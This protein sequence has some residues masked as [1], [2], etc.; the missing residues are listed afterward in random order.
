MWSRPKNTP[1][2]LV[3][4]L[5]NVPAATVSTDTV[6]LHPLTAGIKIVMRKSPA[7]LVLLIAEAVMSNQR[8][9][10]TE[11]IAIKAKSV[12][13]GIARIIAVVSRAKPV[14][15]QPT[16]ARAVIIAT[17]ARIEVFV[18]PASRMANCA[19]K[20]NFANPAIAKT[21]S[22]V[23]GD[24]NAVRNITIAAARNIAMTV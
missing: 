6:V 11:I 2:S 24:R 9:K 13:R 21:E 4:I 12:N 15:C 23:P 3:L 5:P 8:K 22:V 16:I 20:T 7:L 18:F 19:P 17:K 10:P 1:A 14:V